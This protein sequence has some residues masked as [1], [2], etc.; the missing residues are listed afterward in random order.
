MHILKEHQCVSCHMSW[1][2]TVK[3][4]L[5]QQIIV[6]ICRPSTY[7]VIEHA[8]I[9]A[10]GRV[11][12]VHRSW[13]RAKG[14]NNKMTGNINESSWFALPTY[15]LGSWAANTKQNIQRQKIFV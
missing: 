13:C 15:G 3:V 9:K 11:M 6:L 5:L 12:A 1:S 8:M 14:A 4:S 2:K 10:A 7:L